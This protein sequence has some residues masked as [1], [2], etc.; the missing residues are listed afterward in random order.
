VTVGEGGQGG[1]GERA[2]E[3]KELEG[4]SGKATVDGV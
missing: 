3:G 2:R 4:E 1:R